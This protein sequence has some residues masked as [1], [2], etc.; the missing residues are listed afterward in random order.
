VTAYVCVAVVC[1][2]ATAVGLAICGRDRSWSWT[3]PAVGFAALTLLALLTVRLPGHGTTAAVALGAATVA[4]IVVLCRRSLDLRA[5]PEGVALAAVV[6]AI[7]SLAF[8]ANDRIG[9][10]GAWTNDDLSFQMAQADALGS[11]E[12]RI[13]PAGYPNGPHALAAALDA[14]L[15]VNPS[16]AFTA[17]LLA[18]PALTA[19]TALAALQGSPWYLRLPAAGLVGVPYLAVSYFAQGSFKEPMVALLLLG[20]VL[21]LR[22]WREDG[23]VDVRRGLALGLTAAAGVAVFGVVALVWPAATVLWLAVIEPGTRRRVALPRRRPSGPL[24][25][26]AGVGAVAIAAGLAAG[27]WAFFDEGPGRYIGNDDPGGNF[28]GQLSPFEVLG[29]WR[30]PD[31]REPIADPLLQ[32]GILLA[33]AVVTYGLVWAWRSRERVLLAAALAALAIYAVAR[34]LTLA[35]FSGKALTIAAV[36][37]TLVAVKALVATAA[38]P[39][40]GWVPVAAT[41]ALAAYVAVA[42][43]ASALALRGAHVRPQDRG[44]DLAEFRS[45]VDGRLTVYLGRDNFAPWEL[46]GAVLRGFQSYDTPL[47]I[48]IDEPEAKSATDGLWPTPDTDSVD[49]FLLA[50]ADYLITPRTPYASRP[51]AN[52]RPIRRTR[53][54]VLWE[55]RGQTQ[56]R[57]IL[58]EGDAPGKVLDCETPE[59]R[60]LADSAGVAYIRPEP[61]TSRPGEWR[62]PDR[63]VASG[64]VAN[65]ESREQT[66]Q[67]APGRWDVSL[68]YQSDLPLHLRAG[69][70]DATLPPYIGDESGF[71]SAGTVDWPGG[72]LTVTVSV[73][74]RR[75]VETIRKAQLGTVA[76]TRVDDPGRVVPLAKACGAYVD[77]YRLDAD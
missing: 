23:V 1:V 22:D 49:P 67:L 4:A 13:T 19:L 33:L 76:A 64:F 42:G 25:A 2:A 46:R 27:A 9:E 20:F 63:S 77:W 3:A 11:G 48:G 8:V 34:P 43:A 74:A 66:L 62:S 7:C 44:P 40:R 37:L 61:V 65:G 32:P 36:V 17:L 70:L 5:L 47:A 6:I 45:L 56:P 28:N 38:E 16:T 68:R 41:V 30:Q 72:P 14:G 73:P 35:Y 71:A 54:H 59:G 21:T 29:V 18:V 58:D 24:A 10:L 12:P 57:R 75:R 50:F 69:Q 15:G 51:P 60:A 39:R 26:A 52:Y 53:W 31:F 55:R